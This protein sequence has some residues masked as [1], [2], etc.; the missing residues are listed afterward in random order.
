MPAAGALNSH[1]SIITP[2]SGATQISDPGRGVTE[3]P[4]SVGMSMCYPGGLILTLLKSSILVALSGLFPGG[5]RLWPVKPS[6]Q[7]EVLR[8]HSQ[9]ISSIGRCGND[10]ALQQGLDGL[11]SEISQP[12]VKIA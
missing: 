6:W 2:L 8:L 7:L 9:V 5:I 3:T 12:D 10:T 1:A 4:W 11:G